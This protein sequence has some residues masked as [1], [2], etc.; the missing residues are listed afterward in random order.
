MPLDRPLQ[1]Y[2]SMLVDRLGPYLLVF[3]KPKISW[4]RKPFLTVLFPLCKFSE[5]SSET[6]KLILGS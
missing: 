6:Q 3:R 5:I 2:S 4:L 1:A